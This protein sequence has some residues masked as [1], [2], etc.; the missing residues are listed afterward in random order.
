MSWHRHPL[1]P[2]VKTWLREDYH[3]FFLFIFSVFDAPQGLLR[4]KIFPAI[5]VFSRLF[6]P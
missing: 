1:K 2:P 6:R 5:T 4:Q 3:F